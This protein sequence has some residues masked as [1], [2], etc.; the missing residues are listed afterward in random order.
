MTFI[1]LTTVGFWGILD[2]ANMSGIRPFT[3][4]DRSDLIADPLSA[5]NVDDFG[6]LLV[7]AIIRK[8]N[9]YPQYNPRRTD[10]LQEG[11]TLVVQTGIDFLERFR[12]LHA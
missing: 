11:D 5:I 6:P 10:G 8:D 9:P 4:S 12:R 1:T 7:M 2:L 3:L